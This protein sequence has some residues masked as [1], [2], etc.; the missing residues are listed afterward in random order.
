MK[1]IIKNSRTAKLLRAGKKKELSKRPLHMPIIA[2]ISVSRKKNK[3]EQI[4]DIMQFI[5]SRE[6]GFIVRQA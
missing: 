1:T 5:G 6:G 3:Q 2:A 4:A